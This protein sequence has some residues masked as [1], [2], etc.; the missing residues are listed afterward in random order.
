MK[1][2]EVGKFY[3]FWVTGLTGN[4]MELKDEDGDSFSVGAYDFQV[5]WDWSS[6]EVPC[7]VVSCYVKAINNSG[8][9]ILVQNRELLL[10]VLY[11]QADKNIAENVDFVISK[12]VVIN[13]TLYYIV[14]DAYGLS[15]MFKPKQDGNYA[16]PGDE[17]TLRVESILRKE[18]NKSCLKLSDEIADNSH[19]TNEIEFETDGE[20]TATGEFGEESDAVEFKSTIIYP[21]GA[22]GPDIDTQVEILIRTIAGFMNAKG[23]TLY[24]GVNDNG[25]AVGIENEYALLNTSK[26]DKKVYKCD[27]DGF[28]NKIRNAI[29]YYLNSVAQDYLTVTFEEHHSHTVCKC[30]AEPSSTVI[31]FKE[32]EAYK[33]TGNRTTHLRAEA[34]EKLIL[35]KNKVFPELQVRKPI[36]VNTEDDILPDDSPATVNDT[37]TKV[38]QPVKITA[39]GLDR[40]GHGSFYMNLFSNGEWSWSREKPTDTDLEYCVPINSPASKNDLILVYDDGCV[41]RINAYHHHLGK[42]QDKR[43]MN[44]RRNDA[45]LVKAFAAKEEDML[46]CFSIQNGHP[47]TKIHQVSHVTTHRDLKNMGNRLINVSGM[48]GVTMKDICFVAASN[49]QRLSALMKTEN[50]KSTSLGFQMDLQKNAKFHQVEKT[51]I[52]VCDVL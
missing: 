10:I 52:A 50:Q 35:D 47:Y 49:S 9:P 48:G 42:Q 37:I 25:D 43:Y 24:I 7:Q 21:A 15:H 46:A 3:N 23:G 28:E 19:Q 1:N 33:R 4:R 18:N 31:W 16:Q 45:K 38:A 13:N 5:D 40:D 8:R 39:I 30:V 27:K 14:D 26:H 29:I 12:H 22:T 17:I 11:P 20:D 2:Y 36:T 6:P 51:L 41:N 32:R 44:G 34:I